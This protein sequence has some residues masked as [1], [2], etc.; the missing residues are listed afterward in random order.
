MKI[1]DK[2]RKLKEASGPVSGS[3]DAA[4]D[5]TPPAEEPFICVHHR[6]FPFGEDRE[7]VYDFHERTVKQISSDAAAVLRQLDDMR[8]LSG[9]RVVLERAGWVDDGAG[10]IESLFGELNQAGLLYSKSRFLDDLAKHHTEE[11]PARIDAITWITCSRPDSLKRSMESFIANCKQ[12]GRDPVYKVCDDSPAP[13]EREQYR[14]MLAVMAKEHAIRVEYHGL[15]E[16]T[17]FADRLFEACR[18][19]G[20]ARE[21]IDFALFGPSTRLGKTFGANRNMGLL[22]N[23]GHPFIFTDDD[24]ICRLALPPSTRPGLGLSRGKSFE[25]SL[26]SSSRMNILEALPQVSRPFLAGYEHYL[27]RS[28]SSCLRDYSSSDIL[29]V[30]FPA[31]LADTLARQNG[32]ILV[33]ALGAYGD[34]GM[35]KPSF[36]MGSGQASGRLLDPSDFLLARTSREII[37]FT[38]QASLAPTTFVMGMNMALDNRSCMPAYFPFSYG[39]ETG[40]SQLLRL[41]HADAWSCTLPLLAYHEAAG[42]PSYDPDASPHISMHDIIM[43]FMN[44]WNESS[45]SAIHSGDLVRLGR[46]FIGIAGQSPAAFMD[47]LQVNLVRDLCI[48]TEMALSAVRSSTNTA[49]LATD[50]EQRAGRFERWLCDDRKAWTEIITEF[51]TLIAPERV[52]ACLVGFGQLLCVWERI[53]EKAAANPPA[54]VAGKKA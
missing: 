53:W 22:L 33:C 51:G 13:A 10:Y 47:M 18:Q 49:T 27:G 20:V 42:R 26:P 7:S 37:R 12:F 36:G 52:Q 31:S 29:T 43:L 25:C 11:S 8:T 21:T 54:A 15:E 24:V 1:F 6:A 14:Q 50:F 38:E 23:A 44:R 39:E 34:S 2:L 19:D 16:K 46:Y 32:R 48:Q 30:D 28:V 3:A 35:L 17:A 40:F 9:H 4:A 45:A 41:L 5:P